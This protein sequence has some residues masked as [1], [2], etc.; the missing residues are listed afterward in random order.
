VNLH[1]SL[2]ITGITVPCSTAS[3]AKYDTSVGVNNKCNTDGLLSGLQLCHIR[4]IDI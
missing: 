4:G 3:S 1:V 2:D